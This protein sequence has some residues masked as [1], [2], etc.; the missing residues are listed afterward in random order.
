MVVIFHRRMQVP[1]RALFLTAGDGVVIV[2]AQLA[3]VFLRLGFVPGLEY[4]QE[5][6]IS[7]VSAIVI[8]RAWA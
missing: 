5:N 6:G 8:W 1:S 4:I 3:A 2:L 7:L